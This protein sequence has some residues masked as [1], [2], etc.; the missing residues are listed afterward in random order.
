M[1]R[2]AKINTELRPQ[3]SSR[4]EIYI[5]LVIFFVIGLNIILYAPFILLIYIVV[6]IPWTIGRKVSRSVWMLMC[7]S[8]LY[9]FIGFS[10]LSIQDNSRATPYPIRALIVNVSL[11]SLI[12]YTLSIQT[13]ENGRKLLIAFLIGSFVNVFIV[14]G[15]SF[16]NTSTSYGYGNLY[17]PWTGSI[18]NSPA[19]SNSLSLPFCF[20]LFYT[21]QNRNALIKLMLGILS[22]V[23]LLCAVFMGG[24]AFFIIAI[25]CLLFT[26]FAKPKKENIIIFLILLILIVVLFV[27]LGNRM[28][29]HIGFLIARIIKWQETG[30]SSLYRDGFAKMLTYPLGGF[31]IDATIPSQWFHNIWIDTSRLGGWLLLSLL[32]FLNI[33]LL[34]PLRRIGKQDST[35]RFAMLISLAALALMFQ[36][37]I[38]EGNYRIFVTYCMAGL[39]LLKREVGGYMNTKMIAS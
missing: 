10:I 2:Y 1:D 3:S 29:S 21:F 4:G 39:I 32:V 19:F 25:G 5:L 38:L 31:S 30:R 17:N 22:A 26:L 27:I 15:Y 9:I 11:L 18:V 23:A 36:D 6:S 7:L 28:S 14:V 13:R 12:L 33:R 16:L 35:G 8:I 37:V 20:F 34:A 24:R